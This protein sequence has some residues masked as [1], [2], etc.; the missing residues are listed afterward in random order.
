MPL[1]IIGQQNSVFEPDIVSENG[2]DGISA[3]Q[4]SVVGTGVSDQYQIDSNVT[5]VPNQP[6]G[7]FKVVRRSLETI[8]G[9]LQ[10]LRVSAEGGSPSS[11]YVSEAGYQYNESVEPGL[12]T[13]PL[14]QLTVQYKLVWLSPSV[15]VTTNSGGGDA[16][17]AKN[18]AQQLIASMSVEIIQNKP[19]NVAGK[20]ITND[21]KIT[22]TSIEKAGGLWRVRATATKGGIPG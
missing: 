5:G 6:L 7:S 8:A 9:P 17:P 11:A 22:G 16:G 18:L 3:F 12:I 4:F 10:R 20:S 19:G 2:R 13:L 21:V 14:A 1:T 15:T